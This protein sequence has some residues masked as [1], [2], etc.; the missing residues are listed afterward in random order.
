[1]GIPSINSLANME[2]MLYGGISGNRAGC[3]SVYNGYMGTSQIDNY[4]QN[5]YYQFGYNPI[6]NSNYGNPLFGSYNPSYQGVTQGVNTGVNT[7]QTFGANQEDINTLINYHLKGLTPSESLMGAAIGGVTFGLMNNPRMVVHP[8]NSVK[9]TIATNKI[10]TK[11]KQEGTSLYDLWR[12]ESSTGVL[13][14]AYARTNKLEALNPELWKAGLFRKSL[15]KAEYERLK[16]LM[17]KALETTGTEEEKLKAIAKATEE[18]K[19]ATN[20]YTG[21][22]P[23]GLRAI[24][25]QKP[26]QWIRNKINPSQYKNFDEV[27][28]DN[29]KANEKLL[30]EEAGT[31]IKKIG[32]KKSLAKSCGIGGA[33]LF[34][35]LEFATSIDN[36][37]AAF[38]KDSG[39]GMTQ[40]G[41]TAV[42]GAGSAVGW[43]VGEGIGAWAG[44]KAGAALGTAVAPGVGTAIGAVAGLVGGSIG[45]WLVG[46]F[47]HHIVGT[48]VGEKVKA[49]KLA[50][51]PQ[52]Q[53]ELLQMT[54]QQA[55]NDKK[56]DAKTAQAMQNV[57]NV[58]A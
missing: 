6:F 13:Q 52:G 27:V 58:Y 45:M 43:A 47:T 56:L 29:L 7:Q 12:K 28:A 14:E 2:Y 37:K 16:N 48:D 50:Q 1:M 10:F 23:R 54:M 22:I 25:L 46:K 42:K 55:Q 17:V 33:L 15:D 57:L 44:A 31:G 30:L 51:T 38:S 49:Q 39:T 5:P 34:A 19:R 18:I 4:A 36:I 35:G 11:A 40:L 53:V 32:L 26:M 8:W 41:Q 3:P 20:A 24:G 21:Y 9:A